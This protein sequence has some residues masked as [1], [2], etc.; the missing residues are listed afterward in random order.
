MMHEFI[1]PETNII[2]LTIW[3]DMLTYATGVIKDNR[4]CVKFM[5]ISSTI[6]R[7]RCIK[8]RATCIET[9]VII[10]LYIYTHIYIYMCVCDV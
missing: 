2:N 4:S 10:I 6:S 8:I 9:S 1:S 5:S 7:V 3:L